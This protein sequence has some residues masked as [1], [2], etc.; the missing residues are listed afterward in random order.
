MLRGRD[1]S[2]NF[3]F[4]CLT[5]STLTYN[6]SYYEYLPDNLT[7]NSAREL[8]NKRS[9]ALADVSNTIENQEL[10]SFLISL[11]ISQPVWIAGK[12]VTYHSSRFSVPFVTLYINM[13]ASCL[14][15]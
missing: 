2:L 14:F 13:L 5:A 3:F 1:L 11:N 4:L 6:E 15:K 12:V 7:W 9:G 10:T 8:C